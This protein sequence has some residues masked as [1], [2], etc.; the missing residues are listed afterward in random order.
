M[1]AW[2][3]QLI[4][5]D[6]DGTLLNS[7]RQITL[8]VREA[9]AEARNRGVMVIP[10][11]GRHFS[12]TRSIAQQAGMGDAII[13]G[14]GALVTTW[15]GDVIS[16]KMLHPVR[17][18]ELLKLCQEYGLNSNL[19]ANDV[20][21]TSKPNGVT[22]YYQQ[23]NK[24]LPRGEC[25]NLQFV[26]SMETAVEMNA[27][28]ILKIEIFPVPDK[29]REALLELLRSRPDVMP[30][31]D[32]CHSVELHASG[33]NKGTGLAEVAHYYDI[34]MERIIAIGDGK[35]DVSMLHAAGIGAAMGNAVQEARDAADIIL[36]S[37]DEDGVAWAI[38]KYVRCGEE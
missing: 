22:E 35:N 31:G 7:A 27:D 19:Y 36:P 16:A 8:G 30:E 4:A 24:Q 6:I 18:L 20:L 37:H 33:V 26:S 34:P 17:C 25:C 21:Y 2:K 38:Q 10:C 1:T 13:C 11:S 28:R 12:G 5:L 14:N 15:H 3:P 9:I 23:L 32:L 29:P